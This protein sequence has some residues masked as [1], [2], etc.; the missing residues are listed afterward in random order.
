MR[1]LPAVSSH[2]PERGC[3]CLALIGL[4]AAVVLVVLAFI[5]LRLV[6]LWLLVGAAGVVVLDTWAGD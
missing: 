6:A 5:D 1:G 2:D 4:A 3:G